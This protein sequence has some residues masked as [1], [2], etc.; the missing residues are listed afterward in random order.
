MSA[1]KSIHGDV[2]DVIYL[3][4]CRRGM[5]SEARRSRTRES[6][7]VEGDGRLSLLDTFDQTRAGWK[8]ACCP[9][10]A[11]GLTY[12]VQAT[13][14]DMGKVP[15]QIL[16]ASTLHPLSPTRDQSVGTMAVRR[17]QALVT[18]ADVSYSPVHSISACLSNI[19]LV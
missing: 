8:E 16:T 15:R 5:A 2:G 13:A 10:R 3:V 12:Q 1:T 9:L 6:S 7:W 18:V 19:L 11:E 17:Q 4:Q 14:P